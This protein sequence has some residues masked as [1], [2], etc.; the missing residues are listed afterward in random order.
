M[1]LLRLNDSPRRLPREYSLLIAPVTA[2]IIGLLA[3]A[4]APLLPL[5]TEYRN[6]CDRFPVLALLTNHLPPLPMAL[7]LSLLAVGL[8]NGSVVGMR[9]TARA[10]RVSRRL[11]DRACPPPP[12]LIREGNR[13][14]LGDRITYVDAAG[15]T[16]CCYGLVRPRVAVT[17]GLLTRLDDEELLAALAH[18]RHHL[19]RRDPARY[20]L[21]QVLAAV[22]FVFPVATAVRRRIEMRM[23]I[24]ADRAA[25]AVVS[26]GALAGALLSVLA[27]AEMPITGTVGLSATEAR[28][29]HLAGT[30]IPPSIPVRATLVSLGVLLA[31]VAAVADLAAA[32]DL[33]RML[34]PLCSWSP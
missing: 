24:A 27:G 17:S 4:P 32:A 1:M 2:A 16:A 14:A 25:L 20:L 12:R 26:R 21:I 15:L 30:P 13:L 7:L 8:V 22:A 23:E 31:I 18:E 29:A 5:A 28:I 19:R 9:Q 11:H 34:C 10:L 33:V 3:A 6:L